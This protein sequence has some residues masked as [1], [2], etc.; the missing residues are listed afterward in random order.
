MMNVPHH[1]LQCLRGVA[2]PGDPIS[3]AFDR[4]RGGCSFSI[5]ALG[6]FWHPSRKRKLFGSSCLLR[7]A[8][9]RCPRDCDG[10]DMISSR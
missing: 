3:R 9:L 6:F 2:Y 7:I 4:H 1:R 10:C 5:N 8:Y